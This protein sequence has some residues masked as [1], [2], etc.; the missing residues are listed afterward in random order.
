MLISFKRDQNL[1]YEH[2]FYNA[3]MLSMI[4]PL[5]YSTTYAVSHTGKEWSERTSLQIIGEGE[6]STLVAS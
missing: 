4:I 2:K 6:Y 5:F 1:Q 3:E